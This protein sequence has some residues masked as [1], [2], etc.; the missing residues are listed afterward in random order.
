[1]AEISLTINSKQVKGGEGLTI[2]EICKANGVDLPT[3]CHYDGLTDV[4]ACRLCLVEI[5]GERRPMP[6]CT[7]PARDGLVVQTHTERLEKYRRLILEL[8]FTEK[9]HLCAQCVASGECELQ[10]LAY[11]YQMDNLRYPLSWPSLPVDSVNKYIVVDH[12]R[13]I[14]CGRC[15]RACD[16][17]AGIHTL[18]FGYRGWRDK[19][20]ADLG[21]PLGESSCISC[22]ACFQV[23]PTG[24]IFSKVSAYKGRAPECEQV[25]SV[26]PICGIGCEIR[27][28][29]KDNRVV[30]IDS[31]DLTKPRGLLCNRG[32]FISVQPVARR[33]LTPLQRKN[34]KLE[35][36]A[37]SE[38]LE[39][40]SARLRETK[41]RHGSSSIAGVVSSQL[42]NESVRAFKDFLAG[43]VG[44][45]QLDS[46]DGDHFRLVKQAL[47]LSRTKKGLKGVEISSLEELLDA[48]CIFV[49]G[50][51][52]LETHPVAGSYIVRAVRRNGANLIVFD[53]TEN[54]FPYQATL[55]LHPDKG[56][57]ALALKALIKVIM[58]GWLAGESAGTKGLAASLKDIDPADVCKHTGLEY[59]DLNAAA[60][61]L[62]GGKKCIIVYGQGILQYKEPELVSL[63]FDLATVCEG[64]QRTSSTLWLKPGGNSI[65]LW[66][67]GVA[68]E[69][70]FSISTLSR[71]KAIKAL[72]LL[73][74]D[75]QVEV[76]ELAARPEGVEF[77]V[78]QTSFMSAIVSQADVVLPSPLWTEVSATYVTLDG[79]SKHVTRLVRPPEGIRADWEL[80]N[81]IDRRFKK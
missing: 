10:A 81:E 80:I 48:D 70:E 9:N 27:A 73:L 37:L 31:P 53:S 23:C 13:C 58:D 59:H 35:S 11:R 56:K 66:E 17:F 67:M 72:Y 75:A 49:A 61:M 68:N 51:N 14:L 18:D 65:G 46:L 42:N 33:V 79:V 25:M 44:S 40:V 16:E 5:E 52:P 76:P 36:C 8:M 57:E 22:G 3:L 29:I 54:G 20:V 63:L 28:Y 34:G 43:T 64:K 15:I 47:Q 12:N 1:M 19:V 71:N 39:L 6:A 21:Q 69:G 24:A 32:R 78:V 50:A 62:G 2:L 74:G 41:A 45:K 7:Y 26:C 60:S 30:K 77:F 4:A 38:A 55:W